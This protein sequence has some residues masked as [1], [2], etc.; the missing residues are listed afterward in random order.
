MTS[1][2]VPTPSLSAVFGTSLKQL[3]GNLGA[4]VGATF[5]WGVV[6]MIVGFVIGGVTNGSGSWRDDPSPTGAAISAILDGLFLALVL[7]CVLTGFFRIARTGHAEFA[8][9]F[10][11]TALVPVLIANLVISL[12]TAVVTLLIGTGS[13]VQWVLSLVVSLLLSLMFVWTQVF[14]VGGGRGPLDA[15]G[16]SVRLTLARPGT[17]I[18]VVVLMLILMILGLIAFLIGLIFTLPLAALILV[19]YYRG[20]TGEMDL[21]LT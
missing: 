13:F 15:I 4:T 5:V 11:P 16:D 17:T 18:M 3:T 14:A 12:V 9:F 7:S 20:F 10:R 2:H 19:N 8:D 6:S 21:S 1:P